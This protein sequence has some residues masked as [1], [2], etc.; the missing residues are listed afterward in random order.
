MKKFEFYFCIVLAILGSICASSNEVKAQYNSEY[1]QYIFNAV[2]LNP[3]YTGSRR[4]MNGSL[5]Y[6]N[7]YLTLDGGP[8]ST[9]ATFNGPIY[10]G[11][12]SLGV[13]LENDQFGIFRQIKL[14]GLYSFRAKINEKLSLNL[15]VQAGF[16]NYIYDT[17]F[18]DPY[19]SFNEVNINSDYYVAINQQNQFL[20]NVGAGLYL[21]ADN[22]AFGLAAPHLVASTVFQ[23]D[24]IKFNT[25][26]HYLLTGAYV[27][28]LNI[29]IKMKPS[30]I[31]KYLGPS[32]TA[33]VILGTSFLFYE[34]LWIG[35]MWRNY[36]GFDFM[37]ELQVDTKMRFGF[38]L[39]LQSQR[40]LGSNGVAHEV[41][42]GYDFAET[43]KEVAMP[44][45]F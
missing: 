38:A 33:E 2:S 36:D 41:L 27:F 37:F 29:Y 30:L 22:F 23:N 18:D 10:E 35:A 3:A 8:I 17:Y 34:R 43:D 40:L 31:L 13:W 1:T 39:D 44:R 4:V 24:S 20:P 26:N 5:I 9:A 28:P 21:Y 42:F 16:K 6:R 45:Y 11:N 19:S 7:Q 12:N 15:G 25:L 32:E 14:Y